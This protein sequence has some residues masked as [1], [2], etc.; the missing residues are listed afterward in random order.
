MR[1][2]KR[3]VI[4]ALSSLV[5]P[6]ARALYED[7]IGQYEWAVQ[8]V[9][10]P[11]ALAYSA[12]AADKVFVG[13]ASGVVASMLLKDGTMQW[14]RVAA[15]SGNMRL[16][17]ASSRGLLSVTD[18]GLV[19]FWKGSTGDL[20]W[21]REYPDTVVDLHVVGSASKQSVI[22]ARESEI[23]SRS[24]TG[25]S[26]WSVSAGDGARFWAAAPAH[27]G[28]VVCAVSSKKGGDGGKALKIDNSTG[29]VT[30][31]KTVSS[32]KAAALEAG[33]FI[34]VDEYIVSITSGA[35]ALLPLCGGEA[36]EPFEISKIKSEGKMPFQLMPW[37]STPGVFAVT[38][39]A[40]TAIFG[41]S[42]RGLKHL[43]TFEGV[44]VVGPVYS[45]HEDETGQPVA[46]AIVGDAGTKIQLLD[47]ASGNVQPA[48]N[49]EGYTAQDHGPA[50]LLLVRELSSGEH[51]T[52]VSAADHSLA[53]MQGSKVNWVRE[54]AL[55]SISH[56]EFFGRQGVHKRGDI[57]DESFAAAISGLVT[58][59]GQ[60]PMFMGELAKIP[61]DFA[62]GIASRLQ[63]I[64][65]EK[66]ATKPTLL[67]NAKE[68]H[69]AEE[70]RGFGA[71]KLILCATRTSKLFALEATTS[72]IVWQRYFPNGAELLG[73]VPASCKGGGSNQMGKCGIW[74]KLLPSASSAHSELIVVTPAPTDVN[75]AAQKI[76]WLDPATGKTLHTEKAPGAAGIVSL[77][78]FP[79]SPK[80]TNPVQPFLVVDSKQSVH[81]VPY[82]GD[83]SPAL[84]KQHAENLFHF[85]VDRSAQAVQGFAISEAKSGSEL[86]PLWNIELGSVGEHIV[87][88]T[89]PKHI[90]WDHIPVQIKG[91]ASILYKYHNTNLLA[92]ATE[93]VEQPGNTTSLNMYLMDSVTGHILHQSRIRG[94][95]MPVQ[96]VAC[97]NWVLMH[98]WQQK[99]TRFELTVVE[100]FES[101]QDTGAWNLLFGSKQ[102]QN[103]TTS[104]HH[105]DPPVP[106][107]QTY[108][109]PAG[110][111]AMGVTSTQKGVTPR[112]IV[113]AL[114][115]DQLFTVS[116][117]ALNPRRPY[118]VNGA[119][120]KSRSVPQQFAPT[121]EE[122]VPPYAPTMP[123]RPLDVLSYY[124][125]MGQVTGI[126][127]SPT[128]LESTSLI[129][130][131]GLDLFF[132]P[133]QA[134][135]AY[136]VL[137]PSFNYSLVYASVGVVVVA[138]AVT[139]ILASRKM[140]ID[141]WK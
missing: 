61:A 121:K 118:M 98:Y 135:K 33:N 88:A 31:T 11:T 79:R 107:Q 134:A 36:G 103:H 63:G 53:G 12:D 137:S 52:V 14:R 5:I 27:G 90:E 58:Q 123:V 60:L 116:K 91:D 16:L 120:D 41:V 124:N 93:D 51:H 129:F 132:A 140:L 15:P 81:Y 9:G 117:D 125:P 119:I 69:S 87:A 138:L 4:V 97:D 1:V 25:K 115:T 46:V 35:I 109:L 34:V 131:Y 112:S 74:M 96:M 94:G 23:E 80:E 38:N 78:P 75:Q 42:A 104:A 110:V 39:G 95:S 59:V 26:Q 133:V 44:A 108:I 64:G 139:Y 21:Q 43:R 82:K 3:L 127:S 89:T 141:R 2:C 126:A 18:R 70:L 17:R 13:T 100:L 65:K 48:I 20:N 73:D 24:T 30:E 6:I 99:K 84:F 19:Q 106:L 62:A 86:V 71:N 7:E 77:M 54:E 85:K 122:P 66:K 29:K 45:V 92:I 28:S 32:S 57:Q 40:T 114:T 102:G 37:Q 130:A 47:P 101:K 83:A 105:L 111:T 55:T 76:H 128:A 22:V 49:A 10:Q 67:P 8:Q 50:R 72:A 136:D 113:M 56:A 68:P